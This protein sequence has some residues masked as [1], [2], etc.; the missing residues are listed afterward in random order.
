[1]SDARIGYDFISRQWQNGNFAAVPFARPEQYGING[2]VHIEND[3]TLIAFRQLADHDR[4]RPAVVHRHGNDLLVRRQQ[5]G[6]ASF[7]CARFHYAV[8]GVACYA[9]TFAAVALTVFCHYVSPA[10]LPVLSNGLLAGRAHAAIITLAALSLLRRWGHIVL[11]E[12]F[13]CR[14][15]FGFH[16]LDEFVTY[17]PS[18]SLPVVS[19]LNLPQLSA[20][21]GQFLVSQCV[22]LELVLGD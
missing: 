6:M 18:L 1:M 17:R 15:Y 9:L 11:P 20:L 3:G 22:A 5:C 2:R 4:L 8:V 16:I 7:R 21:A 14:A 13:C 12:C 19:L 10:L